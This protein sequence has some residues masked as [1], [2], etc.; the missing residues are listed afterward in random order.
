MPLKTIWYSSLQI[1]AAFG[2]S[3]NPELCDFMKYFII[4]IVVCIEEKNFVKLHSSAVYY[5]FC[6]TRN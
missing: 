2:G 6:E 3:I 5:L 1:L 4:N